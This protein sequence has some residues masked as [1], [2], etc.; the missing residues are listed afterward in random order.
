MLLTRRLWPQITLLKEMLT[1]NTNEMY[2]S[3]YEEGPFYKGDLV[4]AI[5]SAL[6]MAD[7]NCTEVTIYGGP[8]TPIDF[9]KHVNPRR[10]I[11][12]MF[13]CDFPLE[14]FSLSQE[15]ETDLYDK[16]KAA[17]VAVFT[18]HPAFEDVGTIIATP[19]QVKITSIDPLHY[20]VM[21]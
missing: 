18:Q 2:Y 16:L 13:D 17:M 7:E 6:D 3:E 21:A 20:E 14:D 19:I 8:L 9:T 5:A 11:E 10:A 15:D 1:L 12:D 4:V